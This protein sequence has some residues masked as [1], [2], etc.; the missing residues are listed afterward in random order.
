MVSEGSV[1]PGERRATRR[2]LVI[3]PTYDEADNIPEIVPRVLAQSGGAEY[4][5]LVVD[6]NSPDGTAE[7]VKALQR[8]SDRLHLLERPGKMGLGTAYLDG[9]RY[10]IENGFDYILEM[11]ADFSHNPD[12]LPRFIEAMRTHDIVLGS[13]YITGV[14]VVNWPLKRLILSYGA[15]AY[16]RIVTGLPV[17]DATGG[18]KCFR[19]E[20]LECLDFD[21]VKSDG[22]AFQ[23]EVTFMLW[24]KGF[25][26]VEIPII[27]EDRRVGVSK[28]NRRI[29]FE[30]VWMVWRL[31]FLGMFGRLS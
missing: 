7:V 25:R 4:H 23:I 5:V 13:R 15:N 2:A 3:I 30:A 18:F 24:K 20:A 22:Y 17:Q 9:F 11:D 27:F 12:S 6:D 26:V 14:T 1:I 19:R 29:M 8:S 10:A 21:R 16:T 28:M 31:R